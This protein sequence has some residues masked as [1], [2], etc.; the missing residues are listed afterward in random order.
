MLWKINQAIT[1]TL[2]IIGCTARPNT[3][4]KN[5]EHFESTKIVIIFL[6]RFIND[7]WF[8]PAWFLIRRYFSCWYKIWNTHDDFIK[9]RHFPRYWPFVRGIHR[10]AVNSPHK[11]QWREAVMFSFIWA[12]INTWV[13]NH[14][15]CDLRRHCSH[16]D[17]TLMNSKLINVTRS[18]DKSIHMTTRPYVIPFTDQ[19]V[20]CEITA[21][22]TIQIS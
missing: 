2:V 6:D 13:N 3:L 1:T 4:G 9:W 15:A 8:P 7:T 22:T 10:S 14:K 21:F 16:Y 17:V 19:C 5:E 11:G 20:A 12:W 18:G